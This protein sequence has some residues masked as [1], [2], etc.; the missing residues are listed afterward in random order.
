MYSL[1]PGPNRLRPPSCHRYPVPCPLLWLPCSLFPFPLAPPRS[2]ASSLLARCLHL[3]CWCFRLVITCLS[4]ALQCVIMF[5]HHAANRGHLNIRSS[6]VWA[7]FRHGSSSSGQK[8][9]PFFVLPPVV[10]TSS[11]LADIL[12]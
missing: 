9:L 12:E 3:F 7:G 4:M 8:F 11:P 1:S 6:R 10:A 5:N 2:P